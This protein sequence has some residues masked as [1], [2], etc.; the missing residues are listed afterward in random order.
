[1]SDSHTVQRCRWA[2]PTLFQKH[3]LWT[4]AEDHPWSGN[5]DGEARPVTDT[6]VCLTCG[7]WASGDPQAAEKAPPVDKRCHCD[8][9]CV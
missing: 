1:M 6:L 8:C 2:E 5:A 3:P 9:D 7:R 4:A